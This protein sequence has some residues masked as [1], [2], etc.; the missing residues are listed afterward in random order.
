MEIQNI[1]IAGGG[2]MGSQVAWQCAT[3]G[4]NVT[5]Y[6]IND[7]GLNRC[8][9]F[10]DAHQEA[11][12]TERGVDPAETAAARARIS[13]TTDLEG[14]A[15]HVEAIIEQVP[16]RIDIKQDFW[17]KAS[18]AAPSD[19]LLM[20]NT[21]SLLPSEIAPSVVGP[22]RFTTLHFCVPVWDANIGEVM[23]AE[24]TSDETNERAVAL[25]KQIGLV[26][27]RVRREQAG[28]VLNSLLIPFLMAA[29]D[30][31][32]TGVSEP[33]TIDQVWEICN[34]SEIG[35]CRMVDMTGMNVAFHIAHDLGEAGDERAAAI[36]SYLKTEFID[37]G[38]LGMESGEGFYTYNS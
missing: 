12:E 20:S 34:R 4:L 26:P 11:F 15:A 24:S 5:I 2:V 25:A 3:H 21:S 22:E 30:L 10:L 19:A 17:A 16:E 7:D 35:P 14:T 28:Y 32:R 18:A 31:V 8:R 1:L 29:I 23:G 37:Q 33:E 27:V 36:A 9:E 13:L 38:K 6:D